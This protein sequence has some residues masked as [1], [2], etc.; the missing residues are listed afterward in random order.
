[1]GRNLASTIVAIVALIGLMAMVYRSPQREDIVFGDAPPDPAIEVEVAASTT[2]WKD[3]AF[4]LSAEDF[5]RYTSPFGDRINPVTGEQL[6]HYGVDIA[7][8][9]G[10]WVHAFWSGEVTDVFSDET[11]GTGI[12]IQ[13]G[14]WRHNYCHLQH[15]S[16]IVKQGE[17][18]VTGQQIGKTGN[19]GRSNGPHLHW[20]LK[21]KNDWVDPS[22]VIRKMQQSGGREG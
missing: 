3:A 4:P 15:G 7:V 12:I 14:N 9:E 10:R 19:T 16:P 1:M 20:G 17:R 13:S 2:S 8:D 18:V 5:V 21:Y 11:C 6:F 22:I